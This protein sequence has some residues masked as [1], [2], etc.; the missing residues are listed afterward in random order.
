MSAAASRPK[1]AELFS[2]ILAWVG[3][4]VTHT[5]L[6]TSEEDHSSKALTTYT[7]HWV[8]SWSVL[9][10][11]PKVTQ[12][13]WRIHTQSVIVKHICR[14]FPD[15]ICTFSTML[16][17]LLQSALPWQPTNNNNHSHTV[18]ELAGNGP[19]Q[20]WVCLYKLVSIKLAGAA[21]GRTR[22]HATS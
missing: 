4:D 2:Y 5:P 14:C 20:V 19:L 7:S 13:H 8:Q 16:T 11:Q 17:Q 21:R 10:W 15:L 12:T 1:G 6:N 22:H 18:V 9:P 3:S